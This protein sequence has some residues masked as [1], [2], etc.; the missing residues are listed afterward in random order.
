MIEAVTPRILDIVHQLFDDVDAEATDRPLGDCLIRPWLCSL[1][2][3][4]GAAIVGHFHCEDTRAQRNIYDN[5]VWLAI[6]VPIS[7]HVRDNFIQDQPY[8]MLNPIRQPVAIGKLSDA[9]EESGQTGVGIL[10]VN[11]EVCAA[12]SQVDAW[13]R[14]RTLSARGATQTLTTDC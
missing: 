13:S 4:K 3:V 9:V 1:Q 14:G 12:S 7:D 2:R 6:D 10:D 5:L 11:P 8:V